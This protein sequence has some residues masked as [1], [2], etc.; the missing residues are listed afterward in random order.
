MVSAQ[1]YSPFMVFHW[2]NVVDCITVFGFYWIVHYVFLVSPAFQ[3][4]WGDT[5]RWKRCRLLIG[6]RE[7]LLSQLR[8]SY[9]NS[10]KLCQT[11]QSFILLLSFSPGWK[12]VF[13]LWQ[14][15]T[16]RETWTAFLCV[17]SSQQ[18]H[19]ALL[20]Q[21]GTPREYCVLFAVDK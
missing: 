16:Y 17:G 15:A 1:L 10:V 12:F 5:K 2:A 14:T 20:W 8:S 19:A 4:N 3:V 18:F 6:Q 9:H 21:P 7:A 13:V 11:L